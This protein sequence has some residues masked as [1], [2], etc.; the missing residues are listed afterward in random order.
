M[1][2]MFI[3]LLLALAALLAAPSSAAA[4]FT[5]GSF[6]TLH[7]GQGRAPY[8]VNKEAILRNLFTPYDVVMLQEV[9]TQANLAN[10]TPPGTHF[11]LATPV[12]GPTTYKEAYAFLVRNTLT[13]ATPAIITGVG[14]YARPPA[15]VLLNQNGTTTWVV[16]Y[17]AVYGNSIATR[18]NEV[19]RWPAVILGFQALMVGGVTHPRVVMGGDWNLAANDP[20]FTAVNPGPFLVQPTTRTSLKRNGGLSQPY[21]HFLWDPNVVTIPVTQV[22]APP[23]PPGS[24][25]GWRQQVSD[26]LGIAALVQ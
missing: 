15:G 2:A 10:V 24:T 14:G 19:S 18:R 8:Q 3:S 1:K 21:D 12:Q 16:D 4:Q 26:H 22:V 7:L 5:L 13:A 6:N 25:L 23:N 20:A 17:H 9:M 11:F